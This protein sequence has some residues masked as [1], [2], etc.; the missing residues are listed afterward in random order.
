[1]AF[2]YP[3]I[4]PLAEAH[5]IQTGID[6]PYFIVRTVLM[7]SSVK[8]GIYNTLIGRAGQP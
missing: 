4:K 5:D 6:K 1:M 7:T 2:P 8:P 3:A